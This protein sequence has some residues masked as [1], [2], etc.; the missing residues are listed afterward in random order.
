MN[1]AFEI[2]SCITMIAAFAA[3]RFPWWLRC[4]GLLLC[5]GGAF[6]WGFASI[7]FFSMH[8]PM[9]GVFMGCFVLAA[10]LAARRYLRFGVRSRSPAAKSV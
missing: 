9:M 2:L 7:A 4:A 5:I 8:V 3:P 10:V 6:R 1:N